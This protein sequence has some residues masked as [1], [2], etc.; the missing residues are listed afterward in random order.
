MRFVAQGNK[1]A[2]FLPAIIILTAFFFSFCDPPPAAG[3]RGH[4]G[5]RF[6]FAA[7]VAVAKAMADQGGHRDYEI[8]PATKYTAAVAL[9]ARVPVSDG[10]R[11]GNSSGPKTGSYIFYRRT[12]S[13]GFSVR[14][15]GAVGGYREVIPH[16]R[17]HF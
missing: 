2:K 7:T 17:L 3:L 14:T 13:P 8:S 6:F 5:L 11:A 10:A 12:D 9:C 1:K 4:P 15:D 16:H